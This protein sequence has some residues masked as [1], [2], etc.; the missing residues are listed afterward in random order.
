VTSQ[1]LAPWVPAGL[2]AAGWA[3]AFAGSALLVSALALWV[4]AGMVSASWIPRPG[5]IDLWLRG[6]RLAAFGAGCISVGIGLL[7]EQ[8][9]LIAVGL[10]FAFEETMETSVCLSALARETRTRAPRPAAT[11]FEQTAAVDARAA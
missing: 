4:R 10:A 2:L 11:A 9:W 3:R 5:H 1:L 7:V 6:F 8:S